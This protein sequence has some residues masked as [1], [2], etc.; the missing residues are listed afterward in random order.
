MTNRRPALAAWIATVAL[1]W[2][3]LAQEAPI[4][5]RL[6]WSE[7]PALPQVMSGHFAGVADGSLVVAGGSY[8]EVSPW[9]GGE[10]IWLDGVYA[11]GDPAG[12]WTEA[13]PLPHAL[14]YG[15]MGSVS[16]GMVLAGGSDGQQHYAA[17]YLLTRSGDQLAISELPN[18]PEACA[19][20]G[21]AVLGNTIYVAGG[22]RAPDSV[23]AMHTFW[24]LDTSVDDAV[25]QALEPWPGPARILPVVF[26]QEGSV[27]VVSGADL[28]PGPDGTAK[29]TY[30]TDGY[31]YTP[32]QGWKAIAP[33][34][35]PVVAAAS[36]PIGPSSVMVFSGDDGSL[37]DR[38]AELGDNH[39]GFPSS[40]WS[41]NTIT[42]TWTQASEMPEAVVTTGAVQWNDRIVIPGG[43]DR[44]GHRVAAV[45]AA[46]ADHTARK[47]LVA[48]DY[49]VMGLYFAFL[50]AIGFYFSKR[51]KS[52]ADFFLGGKRVPWWAAGISIFGTLLSAITF[53]AVPATSFR[54]DWVYFVGN[55]SIIIVA[56]I[57][58][59]A[60]LPFFRRLD[61]TSAYEYLEKRFNRAVR[62]FGSA[63][64]LLFQLGRVGVVLYLPALA[65][66]TST[67]LD[68]RLSIIVMGVL[69]TLYTVLGGI[70]A[71][72]WTDVLQV[73][74]LLG[75]ALLCLVIIVIDVDG[76]LAA[77]VSTGMA[78]D[79]FRL[80]NWTWEYTAAAF[81]VV[82]IG[83][84]LENMIPYTTDQTVVQR[85]LTTPTEKDAARSIWLG[86]FISIPS[87]ILFFGVGTALYA[88]YKGHPQELDPSLAT[89][90]IF[91]L[92]II[93]QLPAGISGLIIAAV[94]AAAMSSLDSSLNS[95]AA[96]VV[97]DFYKPLVRGANERIAFILARWI[98]VLIGA[99]GTGTA[100]LMTF[101]EDIGSVWEHYMKL[102]G[103][104]GGGLAG[105]FALGIFTRRA[106]GA[107]A[108][109][110]AAA[111]AVV[112]YFVQSQSNLSF[113]LYSTVG[114]VTSFVVG[115]LASFLFG[116]NNDL[117]GLTWTTRTR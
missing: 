13:A 33:S 53:L 69:C 88:F 52:S 84:T 6:D 103:L 48:P 22:Q 3:A 79:K 102:I 107:G 1:S 112:L 36:A 29:R 30:L 63:A 110:G 104:F 87:A 73:F 5:D 50:V 106:T 109:M 99:L 96:V 4:R 41:Y 38:N 94:F 65:L 70:E 47:G 31:R 18:L 57:V 54:T 60:Y 51:E 25:W 26:A 98:T 114:I 92:F 85:Y 68:I 12:T 58:V 74:V 80:A 105:L 83:R 66:S 76:G 93:E 14:A 37:V 24:A 64:F 43:E 67:G 56:P 61:I 28:A 113:L 71:V 101:M 11:L 89:D 111:G 75:G 62:L 2:C 42:N 77:V 59:Y 49:I 34:P 91:P 39:P 46:S 21:S 17:T 27:F 86:S 90:A 108:L 8:F 23:E 10:K 116:R 35:Q 100:L 45:Q 97:T 15:G 19:F 78:D 44:P 32:G 117:A 40:V 115:Y 95:V 7:L 16:K 81:W 55:A 72:I 20:S 9:L 82:A